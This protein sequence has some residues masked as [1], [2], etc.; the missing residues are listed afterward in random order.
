MAFNHNSTLFNGRGYHFFN[1]LKINGNYYLVDCTYKQFF[2]LRKCLLERIG[3][4]YL[5]GCYPG[6][7]MC[8]TEKRKNTAEQI[9]QNG[10]IPL[11]DDIFKDYMDGFL[12]SWRNGTFYEETKDCSYTTPYMPKIF[13]I[14]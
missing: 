1:I 8:L 7:F 14:S 11:T 13:G 4:P 3:I 12:L 6:V 5:S 9:I 10:Y 2:L